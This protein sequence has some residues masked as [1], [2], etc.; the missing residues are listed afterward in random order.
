MMSSR[1]IDAMSHVDQMKALLVHPGTQHSFA[2]AQQLQRLG[3]LFRFWTGFAYRPESCLGRGIGYLAPSLK[4]KVASRSLNGVPAER[5]RTRPFID[6]NALRRLRT[7]FDEQTVMFERNRAF[8]NSIPEEELAHSDVVIGVD[9]ASWLLAQRATA[10]DRC[11][12]LDRTTGHHLAFDHLLSDLHRRFPRWT[13][14]S[15]S[16]LPQLNSAQEIEHRDAR[17]ITVGSSFARRTLVARGVPAD[18][19]VIT[20]LGVDLSRFRSVRRPNASRPLRFV[21]VGSLSAAKGVP[22][23]LDAWRSLGKINAELW[24]IGSSSQRHR[25]LIPV[26]PGLRLIGRVSRIDLPAMLCQCDVLVL[27]SYFEGFGAVLLEAM[28]SGLPIIA[29]DCT[30]APDL[31]TNGVEGYVISPGSA[32]ALEEAIQRFIGSPDNL[33]MMSR[34]ARRCAERY[35]WDAFGDRW[36]EILRQVKNAPIS[37]GVLHKASAV[38]TAGPVTV[39][40]QPNCRLYDPVKALLAHPGTQHSFQL[41]EQLQQR[42]CLG[43]FCTGIAYLPT[44][45]FGHYVQFLPA[46]VA[47]QLANRRLENVPANRV[48]TLP[49]AEW[50]ALRRLYMQNEPQSVMFERNAVFQ[51]NI[52]QRDLAESDVV[53]GFDTASW[54]LAERALALG[55]PFILDRTTGHPLAFQKI[56]PPLHR[57][58]PE[59]VTDVLPRLPRLLAAEQTEHRYAARIV[60]ASSFARRT[61]VE[62]AVPA[63]KIVVNPYGVDLDSFFPVSRPDSSRP[64]RFVFVGS[65][66]ASKGVPL[67]LDAW[68][69][70]APSDAEMWLVGQREHKRKIPVL[71]GLRPIGKLPHRELPNVL[72]QCDVLILP[73]YFEGFGL[74]LLEALA[75]GL[76]IIATD[77]TAAPDL[78]THGVEGYIVPVGDVEALQDAMQRF[79]ASSADLALMSRAARSAAE[80]FTWDAYGNRWMEILKQVA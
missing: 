19:I 69:A 53:I 73:S 6:L 58:F 42:G 5:L 68:R 77:A 32:E 41:A 80:R 23:L 60:V 70:L 54:L 26:L 22:L 11:F 62:N 1:R 16:R 30:A 52:P 24:L 79:T 48:R 44:G 8:Q 36:M 12:V 59:W 14:N 38:V 9:T 20:P 33:S 57:K 47:R 35:S 28:A 61:L 3:C 31:I 10:L 64:F 63:E 75:A 76:P 65:I 18:K 27:P 56:L 66:T 15:E 50:R 21:F 55:H 17:W 78:I 67:L 45:P 51:R 46:K 40:D 4:N 71:P 7:G 25:R 29:T 34:A 39:D 43:R 13:E 74:V 49:F 72:R 2:L 37:D